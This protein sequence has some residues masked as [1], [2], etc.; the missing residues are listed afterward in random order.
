MTEI[1]LKVTLNTITITY[2]KSIFAGF[3]LEKTFDIVAGNIIHGDDN[4]IIDNRTKPY[5]HPSTSTL[6][7][8]SQCKFNYNYSYSQ[9]C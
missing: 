3:I 7:D 9:T 1:L 4:V 2:N 8:G 6:S 5:I